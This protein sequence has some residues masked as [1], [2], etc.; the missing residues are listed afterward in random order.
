[1]SLFFLIAFSRTEIEK[2]HK[3]KLV[4]A[5][6][7]HSISDDGMREFAK[8][9]GIPNIDV[10]GEHYRWWD[11][12]EDGSVYDGVEESLKYLE[13]LFKKQ[14]PFVGVLG[15]S[16]GAA[17]GALMC[18]LQINAKLEGK[19]NPFP[20]K[21]F[22]NISGFTPRANE[23]RSLFSKAPFQI[24]SLHIFGEKE[25][26]EFRKRINQLIQTFSDPI[27]LKHNRGHSIPQAER[28]VQTILSFLHSSLKQ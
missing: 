14:G 3:A 24:P 2:N 1:M 19:Q 22:I 5:Q 10:G 28:D 12:S 21:F 18:A 20:F 25:P 4:F 6:A 11:S 13:D 7:P 27:V 8:R 17:I 26:E 16:Q 15:F 9:N 23:F